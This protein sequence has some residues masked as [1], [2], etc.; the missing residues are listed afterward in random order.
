[1]IINTLLPHL[2]YVY[3]WNVKDTCDLLMLIFIKACVLYIYRNSF[4][5]VIKS[6]DAEIKVSLCT[7]IE[8][9]SD[10]LCHVNNAHTH[11]TH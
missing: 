2:L 9:D 10:W 5:E 11:V 8:G 1:M 3:I 6:R 4:E 7:S